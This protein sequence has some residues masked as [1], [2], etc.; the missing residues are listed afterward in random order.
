MTQVCVTVGWV[1]LQTEHRD[2]LYSQRPRWASR[3]VHQD[4][5]AQS[6][7]DACSATAR[8]I[9][10]AR[11]QLSTRLALMSMQDAECHG[12]IWRTSFVRNAGGQAQDD[13]EEGYHRQMKG[14]KSSMRS[15]YVTIRS[16]S[17]R[18]AEYLQERRLRKAPSGIQSANTRQ[19]QE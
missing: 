7:N 10:T 8:R 12:E 1:L 11:L 9:G 16:V 6:H 3:L 14:N 13:A 2:N 18:V 4:G 17:L 15:L 5:P 19:A